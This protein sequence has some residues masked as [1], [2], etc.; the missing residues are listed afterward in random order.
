MARELDREFLDLETEPLEH[1]HDLPLAHHVEVRDDHGVEPFGFRLP[2]A[3]EAQDAQLLHER[4]SGVV[5][6]DLVRVDVLAGG[7]D[8][9]LLAPPGDVH[10]P[11][12]IEESEISGVQP[13][14]AHG[15]GVHVV[16]VVVTRHH[17]RPADQDLA[18]PPTVPV[19]LHV[20]ADLARR[21]FDLDPGEGGA[22]VPDLQISRVAHRRRARALGQAVRLL[23]VEPHAD[24][25]SRD[26]RVET[27]SPRH[28]DAHAWAEGRVDRPE[29]QPSEVDPEPAPE[30][31][32]SR[33]QCAEEEAFRRTRSGDL[34]HHPFVDQIEELRNAA[35]GGDV[36][37]G[38]GA[39]QLGRV[40]RLQE[41]HA[42][43]VGERKHE[44]GEKGERV[45]ERKHAED[46]V[47]LVDPHDLE[48]GIALGEEVP[49]GQDHALGI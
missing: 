26:E 36:T 39:H 27:R 30:P 9:E 49:V 47:G 25:V 31:T 4:G 11:F 43:P 15:R 23:D 37:L 29:E 16:S 10:A 41:D 17:D 28:E 13:T 5:R 20:L 44:I 6:L 18:V 8:D 7:Q 45:E 3:R 19:R 24:E 12:R 35:E 32:V 48:P 21:D 46:A 33:E 22:D 42:R 40:D 38:K 34:A 2:G 1:V 14:L